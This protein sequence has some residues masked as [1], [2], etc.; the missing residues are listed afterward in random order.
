MKLEL[1][2]TPEHAKE[3]AREKRGNLNLGSLIKCTFIYSLL[4]EERAA[5]ERQDRRNAERRE[6]QYRR[7]IFINMY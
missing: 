4:E 5:E 1:L 6:E 7:G 3:R 2:I